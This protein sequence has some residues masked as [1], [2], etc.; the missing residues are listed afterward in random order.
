MGLEK[1]S[2]RKGK[3][4]GSEGRN[5]D[6]VFLGAVEIDKLDGEP[7]NTFFE[8]INERALKRAGGF[9]IGPSIFRGD[10]VYHSIKYYEI[11]NGKKKDQDSK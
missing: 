2:L 11:V 8:K 6:T 1:L 4:T 3:I 9:I 5:I 7:Y 10:E